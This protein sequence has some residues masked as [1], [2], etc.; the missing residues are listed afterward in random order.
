MKSAIASLGTAATNN[1]KNAAASAQAWL[2]QAQS[3]A[4]VW[5]QALSER[6]NKQFCTTTDRV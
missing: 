3:Q 2:K 6:V 4:M 1:A 5:T